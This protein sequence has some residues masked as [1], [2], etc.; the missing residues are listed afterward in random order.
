GFGGVARGAGNG[1]G[2]ASDIARGMVRE[3]GMSDAIGPV[4][5]ARPRSP[6]FPD[7]R[8]Q[9]TD[10]G[11]GY[12]EATAEAVDGEVRRLLVEANGRAREI[13]E[14]DRDALVTLSEMLLEK[15]VVDRS[16]LRR[17]LGEPP[18]ERGGERSEERRVGNRRGARG[19]AAP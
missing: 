2:R 11:R 9:G 8:D 3:F 6:F 10:G 19:A 7:V 16:E 1:R 18:E 17:L 15:E 13:L 4:T 14:R 12:S 5:L